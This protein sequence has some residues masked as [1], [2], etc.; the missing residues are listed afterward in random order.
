DGFLRDLREYRIYYKKYQHPASFWLHRI[1]FTGLGSHN[2]PRFQK[3][4]EEMRE[5][6]EEG[7]D[8]L[9]GLAGQQLEFS[10]FYQLYEYKEKVLALS[11][12]IN[13]EAVFNKLKHLVG[14]EVADFDVLW[15]ENKID[16]IKK[17]LAG[18]GIAWTVEDDKV[19]ESLVKVL[20][21]LKLK[22]SWRNAIVLQFNRKSY[23][24]VWGLLTE[25]KLRDDKKGIASLAIKL[26]NRLNINHQYTL[27]QGKEW[28]SLPTKPFGLNEIDHFG[29]VHLDAIKGR[30]LIEELEILWEYLLDKQVDFNGF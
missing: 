14:L 20:R 23:R 28:I 22:G 29:S 4:F 17:L 6:K 13:R 21:V 19:E 7:L 12:L 5:F 11:Q 10:Q 24:E 18:E 8:S 25:N 3:V 1:D 16:T 26:E 9:Q 30:F 27:L 15:L 2:L